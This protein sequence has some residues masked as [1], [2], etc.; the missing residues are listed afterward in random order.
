MKLLNLCIKSTQVKICRPRS[1]RL[2]HLNIVCTCPDIEHLHYREILNSKVL[3]FGTQYL[4]KKKI[5]L[6]SIRNII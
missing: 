3:K 6:Q 1:T 2:G 5:T 4:Q